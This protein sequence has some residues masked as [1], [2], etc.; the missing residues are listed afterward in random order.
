MKPVSLS[1]PEGAEVYN[2]LYPTKDPEYLMQDLLVIELPSGYCIH[3]DWRFEH[4]PSGTYEI[5]VF[6]RTWEE[7]RF[8]PIETKDFNE[9]VT[10]VERLAVRFG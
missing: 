1:L 10:I 7:D 2:V 5:H 8:E 4:D 9:V 3:V 6:L